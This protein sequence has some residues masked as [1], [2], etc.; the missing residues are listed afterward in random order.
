MA[1]NEKTENQVL[2][3]HDHCL[4]SRPFSQ[5][6]WRSIHTDHLCLRLQLNEHHWFLLCYSQEVVANIKGNNR[7]RK[8]SMWMDLESEVGIPP[9]EKPK[10]DIGDVRLITFK[11]LLQY[12]GIEAVSSTDN[13]FWYSLRV[14]V[15]LSILDDVRMTW[16]G[17]V[18][19]IWYK[20]NAKHSATLLLGAH[21]SAALWPTKYFSW[22]SLTQ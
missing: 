5:N 3:I 17:D 9:I 4:F 1:W 16:F 2:S 22:E 6:N 15:L 8:H 13:L 11:C 12:T 21:E 7:R 20:I 19:N 14:I 10:F 18:G